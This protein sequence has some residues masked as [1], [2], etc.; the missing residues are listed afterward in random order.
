M[1]DGPIFDEWFKVTINR[2]IDE[3]LGATALR[4]VDI[5]GISVPS[6]SIVGQ[7]ALAADRAVLH[8]YRGTVGTLEDDDG[9]SCQA[10]LAETVDIRVK[11]PTSGYVRIALVFEYVSG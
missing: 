9:R 2:T 3:V 4:Y 11:S 8:T 5:G 1:A 10:L 6:L 7:V